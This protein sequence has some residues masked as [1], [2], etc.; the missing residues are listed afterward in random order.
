MDSVVHQT[1]LT[2]EE[3]EI[4][5]GLIKYIG[6]P[7][8]YNNYKNLDLTGKAHYVIN[9]W[10]EKDPVPG[11]PENEYLRK[12]M[13]R[14]HYANTNFKWAGKEGWKSDRG[15]VLIKYG[16]PDDIESHS[17]EAGTKS[18]EVWKYNQDKNFVFVFADLRGNGNY[19]LIHSTKEGEISDPNWREYLH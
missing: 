13:E 3:A 9:F 15:R 19:T 17:T 1:R 12:V 18:Y 8:D 2:E 11:T 4:E 5:G 7:E 6:T 10:A 14:F 16:M